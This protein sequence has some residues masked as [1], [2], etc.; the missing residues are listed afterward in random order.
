MKPPLSI[1][2]PAKN[3]SEGLRRVLPELKQRHP[4]AQIIV[5]DDGSSDNTA[6]ICRTHAVEIVNHPYSMGN[7]AAVKSGARAARGEVIV[8]LDADG[9]HDPADI[10][11][12]LEKI[13]AGC[14]MAVGVRSGATQA[15]IGRRLANAFYNRLASW[16]VGHPIPDLT[17]GFRAVNAERFRKF[18]YLLPNGFSYP[19]TITMAFFR[20]GYSVSYVPI[21]AGTRAGNSH[22]SL[23]KDGIRFLLIIFR[24]GT[25]YSPLK[26]FV[27]ISLAFFTAGLLHYI[28]TFITSG[29]FTNMSALLLSTS[30]LIFLIGLVSEQITNLL[31]SRTGE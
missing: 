9:Q 22:I 4:D 16:M 26:L 12:L 24:V 5:V 10:A 27:P 2:L 19:T 25:L 3:E 7:G 11:R 6:E 17:C 30:V 20:A 1:V 14:D 13:D 15:S 18:I 31:Y 29:R 8:F 21:H 23:A 28:Q